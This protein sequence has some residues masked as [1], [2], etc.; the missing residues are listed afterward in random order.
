[1][2]NEQCPRCKG[3]REKNEEKER[4][5]LHDPLTCINIL[6]NRIHIIEKKADSDYIHVVFTE[7]NGVKVTAGAFIDPVV[8]EKL[9]DELNQH[10]TSWIVQIKQGVSLV[11]WD[12]E[13]RQIVFI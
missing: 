4:Y 6:R 11:R 7:L 13:T 9:K 5:Y 2:M 3:Q 10:Y 8:A 1:M 12:T